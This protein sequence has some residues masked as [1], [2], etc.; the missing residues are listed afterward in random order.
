VKIIS[1]L[2]SILLLASM[3]WGGDFYVCGS[4]GKAII[5]MRDHAIISNCPIPEKGH[6][7]HCG[8]KG[9]KFFE[10]NY[11]GD[12]CKEHQLPTRKQ[13]NGWTNCRADC[14]EEVCA[15]MVCDQKYIDVCGL[16]VYRCPHGHIFWNKE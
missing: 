1:I 6:C 10:T 14:G 9:I 3:V 15:T 12:E 8:A 5:D 16:T 11:I 13:E 7:P 2:F 4:K